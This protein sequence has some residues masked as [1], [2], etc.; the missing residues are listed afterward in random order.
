MKANSKTVNMVATLDYYV[1]SCGGIISGRKITISSPNYPNNYEQTTNC[2]WLAKLSEDDN[3][4]V[5]E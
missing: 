4:N 1:N 3:V 2:A 5:S